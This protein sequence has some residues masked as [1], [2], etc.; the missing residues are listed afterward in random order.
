MDASMLRNLFC[1]YDAHK[2]AIYDR[3]AGRFLNKVRQDL[4]DRYDNDEWAE[5]VGCKQLGI[6]LVDI[7]K[8]FK[9]FNYSFGWI[10]KGET[11]QENYKMETFHEIFWSCSISSLMNEWECCGLTGRG[12]LLQ[13]LLPLW[14]LCKGKDSRCTIS[15]EIMKIET[16]NKLKHLTV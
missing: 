8:S 10:L 11:L 6:S 5:F 2:E 9:E 3:A 7:D 15:K 12:I 13:H 1:E 16:K 14:R 4:E